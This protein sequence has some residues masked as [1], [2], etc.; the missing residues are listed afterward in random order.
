MK[1]TGAQMVLACLEE[2]NVDIIFG[3]PGGAVLTLY[4]EIFKKGIKHILTRHEQ[5][6]VHAADGYARASG[7]TG[8]VFATSGP[9]A[10]NL[11]TGIATAY[12]DS[13]PLVAITGQVAKPFIGTDAFQEADITGITM[14]I[15][16]HNYLVR[17]I[18][19][20]PMI[21]K[22]AFH[23]A[24]TGRKGPVLIDIPK[25]LQVEEADFVYPHKVEISTYKPTY[26]GHPGQ[27]AKASSVIRKA[28]RPLLYAGGGVISSAAHEEL[29]ELSRRAS[30]PV[31]TTLTGM[32]GVPGD[33]ELFLG[34]PGMHGT[35]AANNAI[36]E[37]DLLIAVGARFDD[38]VTGKLNTFA[39]QAQIIHIDID[40]A[41]I[42]KN[43]KTH[44]P[45][46]G[47]VK[48]VLKEMLKRVKPGET[49]QWCEK[50]LAWKK[51]YPLRYRQQAGD[52][53][54][55]Q[56]V[57]EELYRRT[58]GEAII[59]TDVG[60]HQM[61]AAQYYRFN[62][63]R[64]LISSGGLGTMG[65]GFPAAMGAQM[66]FP[67][68]LVI[69]IA[70]DGSIQMN[71][72]ELATAVCYNIPVKIAIINNQYLGMVRQWQKF[73]YD[74]RYSQSCLAG[75]PDFVRLAEA[76]G[77]SGFRAKSPEDVGAVI[78]NALNTPGPV[79]MDFQVDPEENVL[80]MVAPN[81][82]I[83]EMIGGEER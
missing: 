14:P 27:I 57:I 2:E 23:I 12:M 37:S 28:K 47:D 3:Y 19:E 59:T 25:D 50:V 5:G 10:T 33:Y 7:K 1:L 56:Y 49:E 69:C 29:L 71:S 11:V 79:V 67:E 15:T 32:G 42:G 30:I 62:N 83:V 20:L 40:P 68:K 36:N 21:L 73:F 64:T 78:E 43:I 45:I 77:A 70:G 55:P 22:E 26:E 52:C 66:A 17:D 13:I 65:F 58:K 35:Y 75:S 34:M 6:A 46:V 60:Q 8:V 39:P 31:T 4:D 76:Y 38:R 54:K 41:E 63:P 44:L 48:N 72:Q 18:N 16:K 9:G 81:T 61:W 51:D 80:P 82:S 24:G 53:L 74:G